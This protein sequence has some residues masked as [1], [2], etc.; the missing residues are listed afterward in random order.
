MEIQTFLP[1]VTAAQLEQCDLDEMCEWAARA[2]VVQTYLEH[3]VT[4]GVV[5]AFKQKE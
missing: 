4:N 5:R 3:I 1:H 2:R